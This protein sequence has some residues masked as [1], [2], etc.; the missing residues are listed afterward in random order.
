MGYTVTEDR[1]NMIRFA[2]DRFV[3]QNFP[4]GKI[5]RNICTNTLTVGRDL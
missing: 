1:V 2:L 5:S 3:P 4:P